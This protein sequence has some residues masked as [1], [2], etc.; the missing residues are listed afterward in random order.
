MEATQ[1]RL[2][3]VNDMKSNSLEMKAEIIYLDGME[4]ISYTMDK[5][6]KHIPFTL[7]ATVCLF[8]LTDYDTNDSGDS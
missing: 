4:E 2:G 6:R 1:K 7:K 3:I 8:T 5:L